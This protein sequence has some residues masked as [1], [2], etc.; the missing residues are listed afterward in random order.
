M[1]R[2]SVVVCLSFSGALALSFGCGGGGTKNPKV[3]GPPPE[4]EEPY[5]P[6]GSATGAA[7]KPALSVPST[8]TAPP[9]P[10]G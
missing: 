9:V 2:T 7:P 8:P 1:T 6:A 5:A 10:A 4:Y 3:Q